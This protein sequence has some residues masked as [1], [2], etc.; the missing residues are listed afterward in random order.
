MWRFRSLHGCLSRCQSLKLLTSFL[1]I[2]FK[3]RSMLTSWKTGCRNQGLPTCHDQDTIKASFSWGRRELA[4]RIVPI[5]PLSTC[6]ANMILL[7]C[8]SG[9]APRCCRMS[10][11]IK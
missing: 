4:R 2:Y 5:V 1:F 7:S 9:M 11:S 8:G 10:R 6:F 3:G